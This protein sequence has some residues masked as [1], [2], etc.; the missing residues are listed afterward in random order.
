MLSRR[1]LLAA[2]AV[3]VTA[4]ACDDRSAAPPR[5]TPDPAPDPTPR[6]APSTALARP[7][8]SLLET[9]FHEVARFHPIQV[10]APGFVLASAARVGADEEHHPAE[11]PAPFLGVEVE[12]APGRG[13]VSAGLAD[14]EGRTAVRARVDLDA[15]TVVLELVV[16]G[17]TTTL[18]SREGRLPAGPFTLGLALCE[19]QATVLVRARS[20]RWQA[21]VTARD[22]L[23]AR[24]DL[25]DPA[26]LARLGFVWGGRAARSA[27]GG[28]FGMT[29]LRDPHLVQHADGTPYVDGGRVFLTW[30]CA[31]A[32]F[33]R[34]AHWGVFA[35]DPEHP[36]GMEQVAQLYVRRDGA[37]LGDH[38]GQLVR[39]GDRWL[40]ANSSWGDFDGSG[41]HVRHTT[42]D[43][44]LLRGVH[45]LETDPL[46]LPT[47][48][49]T[50]DPSLTRIDGA[51]TWAYVESPSQSPFDFRP[52]LARTS[53]DDPFG[54]LTKVGADLTR[55]QTEGPV[56][57][58]DRDRWLVLASD[59]DARQ[60]PAYD[61]AMRR[62][63]RVDAPYGTNIPHPQAILRSDGS[64]LI[65]T[66]DG[67]APFADR[68]GYGGH[69]DVVVY[70]E[71]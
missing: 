67:T 18:G 23:A 40:V 53:G 12:V 51:W 29:G 52:A 10:V 22:A 6:A 7:R 24:I 35:L 65:V 15:G 30:T 31:G 34:Q 59:G 3:G 54:R 57:V 48:L 50:W 64:W 39:D 5:S 58:R 47:D 44:D 25:R 1:A 45:V 28:L 19:N 33:F 8:H 60:Y 4:A 69:G 21:L 37:V 63:G 27:R 32:G 26:T 2:A 62:V 43:A 68:L 14:A 17:R 49:S 55:H 41:V 38:A 16:H 9:S 71:R 42:T 11:L 36:T 13:I 20:G 46:A 66:F 61:L 70:A 56:L